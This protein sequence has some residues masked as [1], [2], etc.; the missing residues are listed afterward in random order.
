MLT[1]KKQARYLAKKGIELQDQLLAFGQTQE[2][3]A[4]HQLRV[5]VKKIK[6]FASL[7]AACSG[8]AAVKDTRLL[9]KMFRQAGAVRDLGHG[10][11]ELQ[12]IHTA[13]S[14]Y[15][16]EQRQLLEQETAVLVG[17]IPL[18]QKKGKKA[19]RRLLGDLHTIHAGCIRKWYA[20]QII[21]TGVLLTASGDRL[22]KARK[23][24]KQLLYILNHLPSRLAGELRLDT[25]YLDRL[26]DAIGLWH[27]AAMVAASWAGKDPGGSQAMVGECSEKEAAVRR[28]AE[29]FYTRAHLG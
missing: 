23:K 3:E 24:I 16:Y 2:Q 9:Q 1:R 7:S 25:E 22:H 15:K 12:R 21:H 17:R 20:G 10:L 26:Q 5:A 14:D 19:G 18:Y 29:E 11:Q 13:P 28:L 4:L 8:P 6:A 27:D